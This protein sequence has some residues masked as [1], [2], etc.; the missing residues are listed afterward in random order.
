MSQ[1]AAQAALDGDQGAVAEMRAAYRLRHDYIVTALNAIPGV[2]CRPGEGAFYA[3]PRVQEA[4]ERLG[5]PDDT[6]L[7]EKLITEADVACVPGA[8]FGAPGYLRL[9]F[10]CSREALEE[11]INRLNRVLTA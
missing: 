5:L 10:A 4:I 6:A 9:S 11:A 2:R 7:A 3:F 1:A 8:A